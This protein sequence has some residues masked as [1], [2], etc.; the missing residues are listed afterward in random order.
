MRIGI[1]ARL[2]NESGV[3]RYTRNL[4]KWL[5]KIDKENEYILISPKL[6]WHTLKEQVLLP[7]ILEKEK[8]DLVHFPYFSVPVLYN[9]PFVVTIHDLTI[10]HF[11]TG[12]AST[13]PYPIY[14]LKHLGY[15]F[16]LSQAI[17]RAKKI[18]VPTK[19]TKKEILD[20]FKVSDE[21]I[22]VTYEGIGKKFQLPITN[23]QLPIQKLKLLKSKQYFFYVGNA[24]PHKNLERLLEAFQSTISNQQLTINN[25][26][27]VLV[28]KS[29]YFY[30]R[31][32]KDVKKRPIENDV[33][34]YGEAND[35]ELNWLYQNA[36]AL[37]FPSLMEGFGLPA[38]EA[39]ACECLV[40]ASNIPAL[41]E[42]CGEAAVYF[43]PHKIEEIKKQINE[44][45]I[46]SNTGQ[47]QEKIKKG[48]ERAKMFSWQKMA[49]ETLRVYNSL[50]NKFATSN[51]C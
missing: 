41:K 11:P 36:I 14:F 45:S 7:R 31:L 2:W 26:K 37:I 49:E 33:I 21:K 38:L 32:K 3:G 13:L 19:A 46:N 43:N 50:T 1:D 10:T 5:K 23:Y 27:L 25:L 28:G 42:V 9:K 17:K 22:S 18:I 4:V 12:K 40:L 35:Q 16:V 51:Y 6:R 48:K 39:M 44:V 20:H 24:Y 34:F 47:Y 8:L 15:R 30:E 29:D